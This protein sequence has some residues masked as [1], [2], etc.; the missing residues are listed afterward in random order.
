MDLSQTIAFFECSRTNAGSSENTLRAE[1]LDS[2]GRNVTTEGYRIEAEYG[3]TVIYDGKIPTYTLEESGL[4][5]YLF[6]GWDRSGY[7]DGDKTINAIY[8]TCKATSGGAYFEGKDL[9][10]LRPVDIYAM[11]RMSEMGI[12]DIAD[13]VDSKDTI[14]I[15]LGN[16]VSY[17]DITEEKFIEAATA[18]TG[19]SSVLDTNVQ[20]L[21]EDRDFVL[22]IDCT[23]SPSNA[24]NAVF[25]QCYSALD[26]SG[27]QLLYNNGVQIKCGN[28]TVRLFDAGSRE[29]IVIRH[30][31]GENGIHIYASDV[32][33]NNPYYTEL[34]GAHSMVNNG[35]LMFGYGKNGAADTYG[36]GMIYWSKL[37]YVDL[38]DEI[39][40]QLACWPHEV[41]QFEACYEKITAGQPNAL[42][43]YY[44][45]DRSGNMSSMTFIA[46]T[47]LSQQHPMQSG[48]SANAGGWASYGLNKYLNNRIYQAF[49]TTWKQLLKQVIIKS[50]IGNKSMETSDSDCYI[51]VPSIAELDA[52]RTTAPYSNEG[53]VINHF[54]YQ[55]D[56]ICCTVDGTAVSYWTRSPNV[57]S[58][59]GVFAIHSDG[60]P[61]EYNYPYNI[62]H[63]RI[64]FSL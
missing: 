44:L 20:L 62:H 35:T 37:W 13:Y 19:K 40:S 12:I 59:Y 63:V 49:S 11:T 17:K 18:F 30:I 39:C 21:S 53:S 5:F 23:I 54:S 3:T 29:M 50:S 36:T 26:S 32:R 47:V 6:N 33:N 56:R 46:S 42:K 4:T 51:F 58:T 55:N 41:M 48:Q 31:K 61:H 7:V 9:S 22:A 64:M 15:V 43:R 2:S 16:D 10:T 34:S 28:Q 27:F 14:S 24:N 52:S 25:A 38:G 60:A 1:I 8:D 57:Q 45:S